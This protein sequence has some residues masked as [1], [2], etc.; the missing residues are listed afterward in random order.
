MALQVLDSEEIEQTVRVFLWGP[1]G[2]GKSHFG[3]SAP[4]PF[5]ISYEQRDDDFVG[6]FKFKAVRPATVADG[7]EA[8]DLAAKS[9]RKSIVFD[10]LAKPYQLALQYYTSAIKNSKGANALNTDQVAVNKAI[11]KLTDALLAIPSKNIVV[12]S[13]QA[14]RYEADGQF[15]KKS[16]RG[17]GVRVVGD[18]NRLMYDYSYVLHVAQR[19]SALFQKSSSDFIPRDTEVRG[20]MD[21]PRFL[22]L[23]RGEEKVGARVHAVPAAAPRP[24]PKAAPAPAEQKK[25]DT[26]PPGDV[27]AQDHVPH[28]S[29]EP[30]PIDQLL[31]NLDGGDDR[32]I[33][34]RARGRIDDSRLVRFIE[35]IEEG[36]G[37]PLAPNHVEKLIEK[38]VEDLKQ[39]VAS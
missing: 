37:I 12:I 21:W 25:P 28:T 30:S 9:D 4:D 22:R 38:I 5:V 17:Q 23:I 32:R 15:L 1:E 16:S 39:P 36:A 14:V 35:D 6:K 3:M 2:V 31:A 34:A 33:R 7:F 19:G 24:E 29:A 20:D 11:M 27:N 18:E 10:S 13:R 8:I 26:G